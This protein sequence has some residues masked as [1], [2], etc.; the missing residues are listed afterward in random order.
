ME[1]SVHVSQKQHTQTAT[2]RANVVVLKGASA[3]LPR[4]IGKSLKRPD[5]FQST[6]GNQREEEVACRDGVCGI[7]LA[8]CRNLF[9]PNS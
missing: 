7:I 2:R 9:S 8:D 1:G 5:A 4:G 3:R 6:N